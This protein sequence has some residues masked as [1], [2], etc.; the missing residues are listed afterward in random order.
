MPRR[1]RYYTGRERQLLK[2]E[3]PDSTLEE[4]ARLLPDRTPDSLRQFLRRHQ[5][6]YR[7]Q[8]PAHEQAHTP[9]QL[10][11]WKSCGEESSLL[12]FLYALEEGASLEESARRAGL[13]VYIAQRFLRQLGKTLPGYTLASLQRGNHASP[14]LHALL[15]VST[16]TIP[17]TTLFCK[18]ALENA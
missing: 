9:M 5:L 6:P 10:A 2:Q 18:E 17:L 11:Y 3:G 13:R 15:H 4:L 8:R 16:P 14:I 12:A 7:S 1:Y